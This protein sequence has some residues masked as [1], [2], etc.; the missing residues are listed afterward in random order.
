LTEERDAP[1]V[2]TERAGISLAMMPGSSS[3]A[4]LLRHGQSPVEW[5]PRVRRNRTIRRSSAVP[6]RPIPIRI[7]IAPAPGVE[8]LEQRRVDVSRAPA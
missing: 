3:L 8:W 6:I 1:V 5:L 2:A 4:V 7:V